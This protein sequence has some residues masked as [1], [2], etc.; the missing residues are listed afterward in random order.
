MFKKI[1][2]GVIP[3]L[4]GVIAL[5]GPVSA[6]GLDVLGSRAAAM[7]AFVAVA[8]DASAVAWNPAGL[9][10]GPIFN[11]Q[12]G[13]GRSTHQP[14]DPLPLDAAAGRTGTT[15]LAIGTTPVGLAYYR[16]ASTSVVVTDPAAGGTPGR[17][18]RQVR[19]R[20]LVTSHVGATVQQSVGDYLTLGATLKLVHGSTGIASMHAT[21]WDDAFGQEDAIEREGS[22]RGDLDF[23]AMLAAGRMRAGVVVRN[24]TSPGFGE[25]GQRVELERH[26]RIGGAWANQWPGLSQTIVSVDADLTRLADPSG[27]RRDVAAGAE[28]W[29]QDQRIG[30]RGGVRASTIGDA[31]VVLSAGGS[32]AV[33]AGMYVDVF[34]AG[35]PSH[36]RAWGL[37][38][39]LTY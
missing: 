4:L 31:R 25:E 32:Y 26:V 18:D 19:L 15:L 27:D 8:D 34:V 23:G 6:Q 5:G 1:T 10:S 30:V 33:R 36:E 20:R 14:S 29:L 13:L 7:A 16:L 12:I 39:R 37:A 9:V 28:R 2:T 3:L 35:G 11:L 24:M 21:S 38:A 22:A 17:Q